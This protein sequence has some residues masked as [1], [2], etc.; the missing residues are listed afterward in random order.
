MAA[1]CHRDT[2]ELTVPSGQNGKR[3]GKMEPFWEVISPLEKEATPQVNISRWIYIS[4]SFSHTVTVTRCK[5]Y[6]CQR[7][8]EDQNFKKGKI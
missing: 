4:A 5:R 3:G 7:A 2:A 1:I 8:L 6:W